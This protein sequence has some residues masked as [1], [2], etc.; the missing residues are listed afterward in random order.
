MA[1]V[2]LHEVSALMGHQALAM[3]W[4]YAH[5]APAHKLGALERLVPKGTVRR[6][7]KKEHF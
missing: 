4:R 6:V 5:L 7:V 1:G 2:P 3:T